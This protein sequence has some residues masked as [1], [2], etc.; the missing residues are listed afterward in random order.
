MTTTLR[1]PAL[2]SYNLSHAVVWSLGMFKAIRA[3]LV[4]QKLWVWVAII[5][6][7]SHS[8]TAS[9]KNATTKE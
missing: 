3:E 1:L 9:M 8:S 7:K 2:H 6:F 5:C 4:T